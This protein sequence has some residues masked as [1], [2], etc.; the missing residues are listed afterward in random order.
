MNSSVPFIIT[1]NYFIVFMEQTVRLF[2]DATGTFYYDRWKCL[3]EA[4][5]N[6][7]LSILF[8]FIFPKEYNVV[9]VIVATIITNLGIC[10]IVEPYVLYKHVFHENISKF[11]L[12]N[13]CYIGLFVGLLLGLHFTM[14]SSNNQWLELFANGGISLAYSL[15]ISAIVVFCNKDFRNSIKVYWNKLFHRNKDKKT[16]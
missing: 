5:V 9:G 7:G 16:E 2:K 1:I 3:F 4:I 13:Y 6:A 10:H 8:V 14:I 11:Y 15:S 12:R